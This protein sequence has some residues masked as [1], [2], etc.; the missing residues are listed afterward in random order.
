MNLALLTL[1][2]VV[3]PI[4]SGMS[5]L[6]F[7]IRNQRHRHRY[8]ASVSLVN[9]LLLLAAVLW[10]G[11][12]AFTLWRVTD[13][14]TLTFRLDGL[15]KIFAVLVAVIWPPVTFY[16]FEYLKRRPPEERFFAFFL[17]TLGIL[18]GIA[19]A[20][21]FL[22]L[23]LFYELLTFA[24]LPLVMH[25]LRREAIRA[26]A[27]YLFYSIAGACLALSGFF[28]FHNYGVSTDFTPGGVLDAASMAGKE[29]LMRTAAFLT[30]V[31]FGAKAGLVP[32]HA[33]LATAHPVAPTP[34][35]AVL[36][37]LITKAGVVAIARVVY[38]LAGPQFLRGT[39]VQT[40]LIV[41]SLLTVFLGSMLAYV[42][43]HLKKRIAYSSVSQV[44]YVVFGLMLLTPD[45]LTGALLQL[46]AHA[47][48]KTSL[49]LSAGMV[50]YFRLSRFN[51]HYVDQLRGVGKDLPVVMIGFT[52]ASLSLVG[53]PPTGG[54]VSKWYLAVGALPPGLGWLGLVGVIVLLVSAILTA[55]YLLPVVTSAFF[56]GRDYDEDSIEPMLSRPPSNMRVPLVL[57]SAAAVLTGVFAGPLVRYFGRFAATVL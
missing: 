24:T 39:W 1:F 3:F 42:E 38:F 23:Y 27:K 29:N 54:F 34:A 44:S 47:F 25:S 12:G 40:A 45:G 37:G 49:F 55:G 2:P 22:T 52:L 18:T 15:A 14:L 8:A 16:A 46:V 51:Y 32:L 35:S 10:A 30:L 28:F 31:G 53:I 21:N 36:S 33:W 13:S 43:K 57:L 5:L 17:S 11:D 48:A 26:A 7:P 4:F 20:A 56:P 41:L 6:M 50:I 19:C 9:A